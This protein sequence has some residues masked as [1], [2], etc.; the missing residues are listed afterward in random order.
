MIWYIF[1][2]YIHVQAVSA[3][4]SIYVSGIPLSDNPLSSVEGLRKEFEGYGTV[5]DVY[6][7][8]PYF[9]DGGTPKSSRGAS[10]SLSNRGGEAEGESHTSFGAAI[11][12]FESWKAAE[13]AYLKYN[14]TNSRTGDGDEQQCPIHVRYARPRSSG[15]EAI[16]PR[17]L[18]IGQIPRDCTQDDLQNYFSRFGNIVELSMFDKNNKEMPLC[19]FIEYD[20]WAASEDAI[21][22]CHGK[23][24]FSSSLA[25]DHQ[26]KAIV[27]K[28]A[29][30]KLS[31]SPSQILETHGELP[32]NTGV[33]VP[34]PLYPAYFGPYEQP[35]YPVFYQA[36]PDSSMYQEHVDRR[37]L[38]V[39][40][41][42]LDATES[43]LMNLF[44]YFGVVE[45][46]SI[47]PKRGC[48]F[49]TFQYRSQATL[50]AQHM[51]GRPYSEGSRPMVVKFASRRAH[52]TTS[53]PEASEA[54]S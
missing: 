10:P 38:F 26:N 50:A 16:S 54:E 1:T 51:H 47:L 29:K 30:A 21:A 15:D 17:R 43:V 27:V 3:V 8:S 28:Y 19:A 2:I 41:L 34:M 48:G 24:V 6:F 25:Q 45:H 12:K 32:A 49:V 53:S 39:G 5:S 36:L 37:K 14:A 7:V 22:G 18:F 33:F 4:P 40:Q 46:V 11:V 35:M 20:S 9:R 42:P 13:N 44:S 23:V 52:A 31:P